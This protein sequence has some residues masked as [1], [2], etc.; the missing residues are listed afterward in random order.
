MTAGL[1][2]PEEGNGYLPPKLSVR[3]G[4][5]IGTRVDIPSFLK[6]GSVPFQDLEGDLLDLTLTI[7]GSLKNSFRALALLYRE[8]TGGYVNRCVNNIMR[9]PPQR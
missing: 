8:S 1:D 2:C 6:V 5:K 3:V 9:R 4:N 7:K